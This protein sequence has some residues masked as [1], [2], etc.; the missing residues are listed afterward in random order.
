[1][2]ST[3]CFSYTCRFS[4]SAVVLTGSTECIQ[5]ANLETVDQLQ[6]QG[7][8]S[9]GM[10]DDDQLFGEG[11]PVAMEVTVVEGQ[12][13]SMEGFLDPKVSFTDV[14]K[15]S[16]FRYQS[17]RPSK[18]A[19]RSTKGKNGDHADD[20]KSLGTVKVCGLLLCNSFE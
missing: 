16:R 15:Y 2:F 10:A 18:T 7:S 1:M 3:N 19:V 9:M 14:A 12:A 11:V 17:E 20:Y 4:S 13:D 5:T 6:L 8:E